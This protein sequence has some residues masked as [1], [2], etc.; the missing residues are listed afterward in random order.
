VEA[1]REGDRA[2]VDVRDNGQ[3]IPPELLP[4]LFDGRLPVGNA[5]PVDNTRSMGIGL[6]L[7]R[8][9]AEAH[10]GTVSGRN[11]PAGGAVFT[12]TLPLEE[13]VIV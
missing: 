11:D 5:C 8:T 10:G 4:H 2:V 1:R 9:I 13:K 3:G 12:L 6:G 7:C